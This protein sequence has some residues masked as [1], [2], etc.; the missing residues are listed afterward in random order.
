MCGTEKSRFVFYTT[1][2]K[3]IFDQLKG[4]HLVSGGTEDGGVTNIGRLRYGSHSK[5][6]KVM[7]YR[8][9]GEAKLYYADYGS[10][11]TTDLYQV[12]VYEDEND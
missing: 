9:Y 8:G 3:H 6:G 11:L 2:S 1:D 10:E 4:K 5:I 7:T 12:L